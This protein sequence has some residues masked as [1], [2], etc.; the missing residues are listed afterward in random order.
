MEGIVDQLQGNLSRRNQTVEDMTC[1]MAQMKEK[2]QHLEE[3]KQMVEKKL[4]E[5][6]IRAAALEQS[7]KS[8]E[9][10]L[11]QAE[12][13][14]KAS[15][16]A[17]V[18]C[19]ES[20][21]MHKSQLEEVRTQLD[22]TA[23]E[24]HKAN[25]VIRS[26]QRDRQEMKRK[27]KARSVIVKRQEEI[28][29][30]RENSITEL[31]REIKEA[32]SEK[33]RLDSE[34]K[35]KDKQISEAK[36]KMMESAKLLES[37]QQVI[38]WLNREI[39]ETQLGRSTPSNTFGQGTTGVTTRN[40]GIINNEDPGNIF[41][42]SHITPDLRGGVGNHSN[43]TSYMKYS[44]ANSASYNP[45]MT[46]SAHNT[47]QS[48]YTPSNVATSHPIPNQKNLSENNNNWNKQ[49]QMF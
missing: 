28:L 49:N 46:L 12:A 5:T 19:H 2:S 39:N 47:V 18:Q 48:S 38:S 13:L 34:N 10:A 20:L 37:N 15:E 25:D 30:E 26:L 22:A 27:L 6:E 11:L 23:A 43:M 32:S 41:R 1:E 42:P 14:R 17:G 8:Q 7:N 16:Q 9:A 21:D 4:H 31:Q 36:Q 3:Y 40:S 44:T 24:V 45:K 35:S 29:S 33:E